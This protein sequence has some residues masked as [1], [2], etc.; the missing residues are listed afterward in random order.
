MIDENSVFVSNLAWVS[1]EMNLG[2]HFESYGEINMV[3]I[4]EDKYGR[5]KGIGIVEF[6][7]K[8]IYIYIRICLEC[9]KSK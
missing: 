9:I 7:G 2:R 6:E 5:S 4:F 3:K 8:C 1:S